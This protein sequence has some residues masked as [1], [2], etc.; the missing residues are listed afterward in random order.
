[1]TVELDVG[2]PL[3]LPPGGGEVIGDSADRR[4]EILSDGD[5]LHA[6]WSRFGPG[7]EGADLHVHRRHTDLF[8]VLAGELTVR[9]GPTDETATAQPGMLARVPP[10]VVHGF[11]N[12]SDAELRYLNFHAPGQGF[13]DYLRA[14]RDGRT[15]VYDQEEPPADGGRSPAEASIG[16][17]EL[18]ADRPGLRVALL[19][20]VDEIGI[21]EVTSDPGGPSPPAHV[22][23]RHSESFYVLEGEL[24]FVVGEQALVAGP[25]AWVHVPA[26][27][28]HTFELRGTEQVRF[29]D[30][31]APS[32]GFGDFVRALHGARDEDELAAARA[33]FDQVPA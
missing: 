29:L 3:L 19:A 31:H 27:I 21:C 8:Y 30:I 25:G 11:R 18:V 12:G 33:R 16:R 15:L 22:H 17:G 1:M 5:E 10:L 2:H 14:V 13:A 20:D 7:R 24:T 32:S 6:T 23:A 26:G 9:L 28:P 4:V